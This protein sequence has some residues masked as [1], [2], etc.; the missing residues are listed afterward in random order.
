MDDAD[1]TDVADVGAPSEGE[2]GG[3]ARSEC[4]D[5]HGA[6]GGAQ[7]FRDGITGA[8]LPPSLVLRPAQRRF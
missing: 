5:G 1:I 2:S 8:A 6:G 3:P 4:S 7:Q